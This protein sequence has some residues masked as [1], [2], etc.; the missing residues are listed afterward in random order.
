[1]SMIPSLLLSRET[2]EDLPCRGKS[3]ASEH[4]ANPSRLMESPAMY[5]IAVTAVD[6]EGDIRMGIAEVQPVARSVIRRSADLRP[7]IFC[8]SLRL[9]MYCGVPHLQVGLRGYAS[10]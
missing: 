10:V 5:N 1:M 7:A 2:N 3:D 8:L 6:C 9:A 4:M